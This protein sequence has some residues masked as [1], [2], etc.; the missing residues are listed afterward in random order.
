MHRR[1]ARF[2]ARRVA[3]ETNRLGRR[4]TLEHFIAT[5]ELVLHSQRV[6][7]LR[8]TLSLNSPS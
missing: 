6:L 2:D 8:L 7:G 3:D 5:G 1:F 4:N